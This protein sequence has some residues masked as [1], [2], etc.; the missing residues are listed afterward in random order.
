[1]ASYWQSVPNKVAVSITKE[2]FAIQ[3]LPFS[4][5]GLQPYAVLYIL[6]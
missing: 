6:P 4:V 5:P 3:L 2:T 1:M